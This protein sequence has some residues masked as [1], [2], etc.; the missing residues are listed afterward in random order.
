MKIKLISSF[1]TFLLLCALCALWIAHR[2]SSPLEQAFKLFASGQLKKAQTVL[3][4]AENLSVD[5]VQLYAGYVEQR[6]GN[7]SLAEK[8]FKAAMAS[9][10]K[11]LR[12]EVLINQTFNAFLLHQPDAMQTFLECL[13]KEARQNDPWVKYLSALHNFLSKKNTRFLQEAEQ[14]SPPPLS[15]W[16]QIAFASYRT[17]FWFIQQ[18]AQEA[19]LENN[20]SKAR[21]LL[22]GTPKGTYE[23]ENRKGFLIGLSYLKEAEEKPYFAAKPYLKLA[24]AYFKRV[25]LDKTTQVQIHETLQKVIAKE[26]TQGQLQDLDLSLRSP[27]SNSTENAY[28][29]ASALTLKESSKYRQALRHFLQL[30]NAS[31]LPLSLQVDYISTLI[32]LDR[33]EDAS[34]KAQKIASSLSLEDKFKLAKELVPLNA[35]LLSDELINIPTSQ[36]AELAYLELLMELGD[37]TKAKEFSREHLNKFSE[38]AEGLLLLA[39]LEHKLSKRK[40]TLKW[41]YQ[42]ASK[43]P[44]NLLIQAFIDQVEFTSSHLSERLNEIDK[45][46]DAQP[47]S[48]QLS[49]EKARILIDLTLASKEDNHLRKASLLLSDLAD[50]DPE[51]PRIA[52]LQGLAAYL[53]NQN[54]QAEA[55]L[56]QA[57]ALDISYVEAYKYLGLVYLKKRQTDQAIAALKRALHFDPHDKETQQ[58]LDLLKR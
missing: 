39:R 31:A 21:E 13:K 50:K 25:S 16:M 36:E 26:D 33:F 52:F 7:L 27:P 41:A 15:V 5:H 1:L 3:K 34:T 32:H 48:L 38:T 8:E 45:K 58:E 30:E 6:Q 2:A 46:L 37:L 42:A 17:P 23:E 56:K 18:Q 29:K 11:E 9:A 28:H 54:E 55:H 51:Y 40:A 57:I 24:F 35:P 19:I 22:E 4:N 12:T 44:E 10:S 43:D 14:L 47:D 49:V 53:A 20:Y